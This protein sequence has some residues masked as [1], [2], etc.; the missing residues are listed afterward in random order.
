MM[1][2]KLLVSLIIVFCV[3]VVITQ[4]AKARTCGGSCDGVSVGSV[5][6]TGSYPWCCLDCV[7]D[8]P[9]AGCHAGDYKCIYQ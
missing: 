8:P 6:C 9:R 2:K 5:E 1:K 4:I 3:L 7:S